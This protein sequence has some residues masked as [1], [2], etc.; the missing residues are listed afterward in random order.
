MVYLA[1]KTIL[2]IGLSRDERLAMTYRPV[3]RTEPGEVAMTC[4]MSK[5]LWRLPKV[6]IKM[7]SASARSVRA[8]NIHSIC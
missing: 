1:R 6:D 7:H 5:I 3:T 2:R 8:L 4:R